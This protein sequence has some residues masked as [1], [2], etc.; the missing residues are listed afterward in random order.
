MQ[1]HGIMKTTLLDYPGHLA[2]TL[3]TGGCSFRCPFCHNASLVLRPGQTPL[4]PESEIL[5]FLKK[6]KNVLEGVCITGGEPTL[7]K[8]L[9]LFIEKIK[10]LGYEVKLDTNGFHPA[11]L[12]YLLQEHLLD[13]VAVDIKNAPKKYAQTVGLPACDTSP[14][15]ETIQMLISGSIPYE[16]RTTVVK[17]LHEETDFAAIGAWISGAKAYYLQ[18]F[19]DSG[20]LISQ[21]CSAFGYAEMERFRRA[22]SPYVEYCALR[23]IDEPTAK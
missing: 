23:G 2:A 11:M 6:R 18:Q 10:A 20:D 7:Q 21:G 13:Y 8:D 12:S 16:F 1:I 4:Y 22:A 15:Q 14:L 17:G 5:A 3:F 9:P 19:V